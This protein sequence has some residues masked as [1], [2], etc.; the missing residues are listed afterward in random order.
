M[1]AKRLSLGWMNLEEAA[2][3]VGQAFGPGTRKATGTAA[4]N[5]CEA[6]EWWLLRAGQPAQLLLSVCDNYLGAVR[7]DNVEVLDNLFVHTQEGVRR[8]DRWTRTR[9]LRLSP[10]R[11]AS[12]EEQTSWTSSVTK[13]PKTNASSWDYEALQGQVHRDAA[14]CPSGSTSVGERDMPYFPAARV[15]KA[16]FDSGWKQAGLGQG[17]GACHLAASSI[18]MGEDK[19]AGPEDAGLKA[20]LVQEDFLLLEVRDDVWT[21]PSASWLNDDHVELWL[22]PMPPQL[23]TGCG[24][25]TA[26][27]QPVQWGIRI[28]DGKVFPAF[29]KPKQ[30]LQVERAKLPDGKGYRLKVKLPPDFEGLSVIYS[31]SDGGKKQETLIATSDLKF[32][33]P[34]T[35]NPLSIMPLDDAQCAVKHGQLTVVARPEVRARPEQAVLQMMP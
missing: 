17:E 19:L 14:D 4:S 27:Q 23:L 28:A 33:R 32:G 24:K 7:A 3:L 35:F 18:L 2:G 15:D 21:G 5:R 26:P 12:E 34:E 10:L 1:Q 29:G 16:F 30:P 6:T 25:P 8:G 22:A 9:R 13:E 31:D 11:L 20:L